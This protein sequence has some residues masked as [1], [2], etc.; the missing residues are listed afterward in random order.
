MIYISIFT[1]VFE[2][3]RICLH[4][5]NIN[6]DCEKLLLIYRSIDVSP[7]SSS[8]FIDII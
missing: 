3:F 7:T 2:D 4:I 1:L 5:F 6:L 8:Q